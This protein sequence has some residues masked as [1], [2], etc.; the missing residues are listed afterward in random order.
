MIHSVLTIRSLGQIEGK[1]CQNFGS[2]IFTLSNLKLCQNVNLDDIKSMFEYWSYQ[3]R[4]QK[5]RG[6]RKE[7][8]VNTLEVAFC[9][10]VRIIVLMCFALEGTL[11]NSG[12][13]SMAL[14][15]NAITS[16]LKE[17]ILI[18]R[19]SDSKV[20]LNHST[21]QSRISHFKQ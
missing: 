4:K 14:L 11:H 7:H 19:Y 3:V 15:V 5:W 20:I 18:F 12:E 2:R 16:T 8:L 17:N 13:W 21:C 9:L 10:F 6:Q 1:Y